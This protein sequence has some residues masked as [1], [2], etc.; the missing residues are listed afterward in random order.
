MYKIIFSNK[1]GEGNY[2]NKY[3]NYNAKGISNIHHSYTENLK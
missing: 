3:P 1:R 2:E